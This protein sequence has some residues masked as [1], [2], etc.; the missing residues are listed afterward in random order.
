M[1]L[2]MKEKTKEKLKKF[3]EDLN[4]LIKDTEDI[5]KNKREI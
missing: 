2:N 4:E 1:K 5:K 3:E